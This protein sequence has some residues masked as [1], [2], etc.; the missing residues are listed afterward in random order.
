MLVVVLAVLV[1]SSCSSYNYY[2]LNNSKT[3]IS[4]Y[5]TYA[6]V[7]GNESKLEDYYKN[8]IAEDK[9]IDAASAAL[10]AHGLNYDAKKPDLL[11][12]YT[13][14]V[15]SKSRTINDPVYYQYPSRLVPRVAYYRGRQ[16]YYYQYVTPFPVYVGSEQR[17]EQFEEGNIVI[18]LIDRNTSKVVW[19]GV[20]KGEVNNPERAVNDIPKVVTK[21]LNKIHS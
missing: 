6:W 10:N 14:V 21:L 2:S 19:R 9:I 1:L 18:D 7:R 17:Q 4:K 8:D 13:A 20:A 15:D 16:Y 12:R 5:H 3:D 11:I